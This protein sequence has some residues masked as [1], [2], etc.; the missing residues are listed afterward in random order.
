MRCLSTILLLLALTASSCTARA[1]APREGSRACPYKVMFYNL[2]NLFDTKDDPDTDDGEFTPHSPKKWDE[3][4]YKSKLA[5]MARVIHDVAAIDASYPVVVGVAEVE[6]RGVLRDLAA[7]PQIAGANYR[8]VHYESPDA[9]GIDVAFLYRASRFE[10]E[11]SCAVR[12][13]VPTLPHFKTRDI[14]TMWG[15]IDGEPFY[16]MVAHWP[17]RLGGQQASEFKRMAAAE[18]MRR[19]ADSVRAANPAVKIVAMGDFNDDPTD[20]S[21][22]EGLG[23]VGKIKQ[24]RDGD[25]FN[26][27][28]AIFRS[29]DGTLAYNGAWNLFDN[30]VVS[31]N[32]ARGSGSTLRL[33]RAAGSKHYGTIF[34]PAYLLQSSGAYRGQPL[35]TF[36]GNRFLDGYSDHL[37]VFIQI[38]AE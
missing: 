8:I 38:A 21:I 32:L 28:E 36:A 2:E 6:N 37:P 34:R 11:G 12:T 35:R 25:L 31:D 19:M 4:R 18:Q 30:I 9:R 33:C 20:A 15:R 16:F 10:L 27:F 5:N 7:Q 14:V 3:K 1:Q 22:A 17:S 13:V 26:P 24:L 29:G 23:A